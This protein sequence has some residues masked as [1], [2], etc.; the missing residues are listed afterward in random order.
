MLHVAQG[1][2]GAAALSLDLVVDRQLLRGA[3][4]A[5]RGS[6]SATRASAAGSR[7]VE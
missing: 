6:S 7:P 3:C 4:V 1:L 5:K 2:A